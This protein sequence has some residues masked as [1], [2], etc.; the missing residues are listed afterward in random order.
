M[1]TVKDQIYAANETLVPDLEDSFDDFC[2]F[3]EKWSIH[4]G[5]LFGIPIRIHLLNVLWFGL[6]FFYSE[7]Y[8]PHITKYLLTLIVIFVLLSHEM[9]HALVARYFGNAVKGIVILLPLGA[10]SIIKLKRDKPLERLAINLAGPVVNLLT[11]QAIFMLSIYFRSLFYTY[12]WK[13]LLH[14]LFTI[15]LGVGIFNLIPLYPMDGGRTVKDFLLLC[16]A[17]NKWANIATLTV[18]VASFIF[19][20]LWSIHTADAFLFVMSLIMMIIGALIL[21][22]SDD[23]FL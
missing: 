9:S 19:L 11:A 13:Y 6:I 15:S 2:G 12:Y 3:V 14:A 7:G 21:W 4:C 16:K 22:F 1:E 8:Y 23:Y 5:S 10:I 20:V 18:S 17:S